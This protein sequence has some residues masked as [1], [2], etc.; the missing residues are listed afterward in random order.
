MMQSDFDPYQALVY[1]VNK[2]EWLEKQ[3]AETNRLQMDLSESVVNMSH[4]NKKVSDIV[5]YNTS[6][7]A[8]FAQDINQ[9]K[10]EIEQTT[11]NNSRR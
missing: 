8:D 4:N 7:I 6:K 5:A 11:K 10:N 1:C 3:L 2:I 9:I